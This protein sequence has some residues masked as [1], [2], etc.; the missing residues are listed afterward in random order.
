VT[1]R[2]IHDVIARLAHIADEGEIS[3]YLE[4]F[5]PDAV[6]ELQTATAAGAQA[7]RLTGRAEIEAGVINRRGSGMQGPGSATRHVITTIEI[8]GQTDDEAQVVSY[9]LFYTNTKGEPKLAT[10]GRYDD[11]F[12]NTESGWQ[13]EHRVIRAG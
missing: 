4:L 12:R 9:Y 11:V 1:N 2:S 7:V 6:W 8:A 13:L 5:T 10:I 3:E